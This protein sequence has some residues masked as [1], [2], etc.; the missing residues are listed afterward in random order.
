L[1][2]EFYSGVL[3]FGFWVS[4]CP[5]VFP[6]PLNP[7]VWPIERKSASVCEFPIDPRTQSQEFTRSSLPIGGSFCVRERE[8]IVIYSSVRILQAVT[9]TNTLCFALLISLF[10]YR[11]AR[12]FDCVGVSPLNTNTIKHFNALSF[13]VYVWRRWS[14]Q[15]VQISCLG[16]GP[17]RIRFLLAVLTELKGNKMNKTVIFW[18]ALLEAFRHK[19]HSWV[20]PQSGLKRPQSSPN[21]YGDLARGLLFPLP[22]PAPTIY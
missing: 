8:S 14:D 6:N 16:S 3:S 1:L 15:L 5:C 4:I 20:R 19:V 17:N 12:N 7:S 22:I 18:E 10:H 13:S 11:C 21:K 2:I 9:N